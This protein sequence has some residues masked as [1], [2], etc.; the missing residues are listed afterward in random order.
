MDIQLS[1]AVILMLLYVASQLGSR[2]SARHASVW[3]LISCFLVWAVLFPTT[4]RSLA[5]FF[6]VQLVS[7]FVLAS[8][9]FF[10]FIQTI[11]LHAEVNANNNKT[12]LLVSSLAARDFLAKKPRLASITN[13]K[14]VLIIVPCFNEEASITATVSRLESFITRAND[15]LW[16]YDY[17]VIDDGSNDKTESILM[18]IAFKNYLR[19]TINQGVS[20]ALLTGFFI[21]EQI[22]VDFVV[23]CD[24]DGQHPI[25]DIDHLVK[26]AQNQATDLMIGSRF[27]TKSRLHSTNDHSTL[28]S[29]TLLRRLGG[30]LI[31]FLLRLFGSKSRISDPTSGFR[32]YSARAL[33]ILKRHMP[34]E[35]PEPESIAILG[36]QNCLIQETQVRMSKR[37]QGVSSI[38]GF[39]S[40]KFMM[41]VCSALFGLRLRT[42]IGRNVR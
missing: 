40:V 4:L 18:E 25:E 23:Q 8:L 31:T 20:G 28:E 39:K 26:L 12:R 42:L 34:E 32:C 38:S 13:T 35:Y 19:H 21:A 22:G 3:L 30:L 5:G 14:R 37:E 27:A 11:S 24:A 33:S 36:L 1:I 15:T 29:T 9:I 2:L 17:C 6:G 41:K 7:N 10:L 16:A